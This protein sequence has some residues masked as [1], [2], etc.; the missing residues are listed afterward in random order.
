ML[1]YIRKPSV[2]ERSEL[3]QLCINIEVA[4][5][6]LAFYEERIAVAAFVFLNKV[7]SRHDLPMTKLRT[8]YE[9]RKSVLG[10]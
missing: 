7:I 1:A 8:F 5:R 2:W 10:I 3:D 4:S 9:V 6:E